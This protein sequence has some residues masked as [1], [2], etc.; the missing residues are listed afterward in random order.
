MAGWSLTT[1]RADG[2]RLDSRSLLVRFSSAS[3]PLLVRFSF[4]SRPLLVRFSSASRSL[5]VRFSFASRSAHLSVSGFSIDGVIV[6]IWRT[7][8]GP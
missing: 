7:A 6:L 1:H 8:F 4:A 5:L 3:R 2:L